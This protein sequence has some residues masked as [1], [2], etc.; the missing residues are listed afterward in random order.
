M[1]EKKETVKR[2]VVCYI[3]TGHQGTGASIKS[4]FAIYDF[5]TGHLVTKRVIWPSSEQMTIAEIRGMQSLARYLNTVVMPNNCHIYLLTNDKRLVS[6]LIDVSK[7]SITS[8]DRVR[9]ETLEQLEKLEKELGNDVELRY[10]IFNMNEHL[11][12]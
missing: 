1:T 9:R 4:D 12:I 11:S 2:R 8:E 3:R 5:S 10:S 7:V 6:G